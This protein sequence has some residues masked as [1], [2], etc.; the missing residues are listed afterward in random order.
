M[1]IKPYS[2]NVYRAGSWF[3]IQTD[4]LLPGDLVSI[5]VLVATFMSEHKLRL[6]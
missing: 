4:D 6:A 2:I 3:E 1:S 5:G